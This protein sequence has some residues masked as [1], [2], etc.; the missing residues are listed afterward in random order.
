MAVLVEVARQ[1]WG[2]NLKGH[3]IARSLAVWKRVGEI[4]QAEREALWEA[5]VQVVPSP[6]GELPATG[7]AYHL[8]G[9]TLYGTSCHAG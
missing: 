1:L 8:R 2:G 5:G 3:K 6:S 7:H 4:L 9:G